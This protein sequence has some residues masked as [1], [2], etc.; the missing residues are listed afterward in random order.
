VNRGRAT[1][2]R[3]A[4]GHEHGLGICWVHRALLKSR[5]PPI[6]SPARAARP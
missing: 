2:P 6:E 1:D 5:C 3:A 4:S